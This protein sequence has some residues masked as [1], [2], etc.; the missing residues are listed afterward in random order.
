[1]TSDARGPLNALCSASMRTEASTDRA[2]AARKMTS[3]AR[4]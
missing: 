4:A 1:M 2:P 3:P